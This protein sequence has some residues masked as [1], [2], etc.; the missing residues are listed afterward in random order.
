MCACGDEEG[1][2]FYAWIH[3]KTDEDNT[4][5]IVEFEADIATVAVDGRD[6]L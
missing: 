6:F 2:A 5:V 4:P 3:N 1:T